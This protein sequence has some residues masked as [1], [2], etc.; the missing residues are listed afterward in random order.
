MN[1][2]SLMKLAAQ[3]AEE[4][5]KAQ[6]AYQIRDT[7]R[8]LILATT[9]ND[10]VNEDALDK[11]LQRSTD[12]VV[13][14]FLSEVALSQDDREVIKATANLVKTEIKAVLNN[15]AENMRVKQ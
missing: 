7:C 8:I 5:K 9:I 10:L 2:Q 4:Q 15:A 11:T 6:E 3:H 12:K 14:K 1:I 13:N